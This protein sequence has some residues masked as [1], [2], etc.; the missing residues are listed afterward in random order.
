MRKKVEWYNR[1]LMRSILGKVVRKVLSE[2]E[3]AT[4]KDKQNNEENGQHRK[5]LYRNGNLL[6]DKRGT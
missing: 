4:E 2:Y 3:I 5:G 1:E 6:Y